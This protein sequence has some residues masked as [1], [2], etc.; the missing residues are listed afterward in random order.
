MGLIFSGESRFIADHPFNVIKYSGG[1]Y[2][3]ICEAPPGSGCARSG[4]VWRV[5]RIAEST[6]EVVYAGAGSFDC[7]ATDLATVAALAYV[8][9][10]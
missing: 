5:Q 10:D 1:G 7:P 9:G 4:A 3:Y 6:G 2:I 8:L